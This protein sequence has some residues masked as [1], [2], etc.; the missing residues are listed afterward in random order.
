M[1]ND[2]NLTCHDCKKL[3]LFSAAEQT[4]FEKKGFTNLPKRCTNCR[5]SARFKRDG[6]DAK[7]LH[8]TK[9][10]KC[11]AP[12]VV[13]FAPDAEKPVYC[14]PCFIY[15]RAPNINVSA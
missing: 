7:R 2:N 11:D 3:F 15:Q 12:T 5:L 4:F 14:K 6:H 13:P 9:C 1:T 10:V 8:E